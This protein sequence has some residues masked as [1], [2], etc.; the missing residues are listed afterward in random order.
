MLC[1]IQTVFS[2]SITQFLFLLP[3][4]TLMVFVYAGSISSCYLQVGPEE[5][6]QSQL[7]TEISSP[8]ESLFGGYSVALY[9]GCQLIAM[10]WWRWGMCQCHAQCDVTSG[11]GHPVMMSRFSRNCKKLWETEFPDWL[12]GIVL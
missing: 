8:E 4:S 10:I 6:L 11:G 5:L 7:M 2:F 12:F 9:L 3:P 1:C